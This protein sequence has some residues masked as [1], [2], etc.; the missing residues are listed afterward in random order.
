M[1]QSRRLTRRDLIT[2]MAAGI[3][4]LHVARSD[5]AE[6]APVTQ[7]TQTVHLGVDAGKPRGELKPI[8]RFF[9]CDNPNYTTSANGQLLLGELGKLSPGNVYFRT[10]NLL[11]THDGPQSGRWGSTNA[12]TE[13]ANGNPVYDWS[14]VDAIFDAGIKRG[15]RPYVQLGFM[16]KAMSTRPEPY[17]F[18]WYPGVKYT[19]LFNGWAHPPKDYDKWA[20]L[21][22]QWAKHCLERYGEHE[23]STWYWEPWNE[24]NIDY[25][26]GTQDEWFKLYDYSV[27]AVR[28]ALPHARVGG[29]ETAN[30]P[31]DSYLHDFLEHCARGTNYATGKIGSPLDFI[32]FHAKGSPSYVNGHVRMGIS[33]EIKQ[34]DEAFAVI[35]SF[36]EFAH[37]P[38]V[39]G[40][41][42]PDSCAACKGQQFG[43]RDGP[44]Y[45]SFTAASFA[46][47]HELAEKRDVNL[48]GAITWSF[49]FENE[50][51]FPGLRQL[52]SNGVDLP[53]LNVIRMFSK[54]GGRRLP[55]ASPNHSALSAVMAEGVRGNSDVSALASIDERRLYILAWHYHDD[56]LPGERVTADIVVDNIPW[57]KG[58]VRVT[59]H[60][61]DAEHG[62]AVAEW[63][64]MGSP[65]KPDA[66]QMAKLRDAAKIATFG[67]PKAQLRDSTV[68]LSVALARQSVTLLIIERA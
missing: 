20:E 3:V 58:D 24:P 23:V 48:E 65:P 51:M 9:G 38:I 61:V 1:S 67:L 53:V 14:T 2:A 7:S 13:D 25:W 66:N 30:G 42:D 45:A 39:I 62:N 63:H 26:Q 8:W 54:M 31:G 5:G 49:E 36:P 50:P 37:L 27:A 57:P 43:Y 17:K 29:P 46:R 15:V 56:D 41:A 59:Q 16:P 12:Y 6:P 34:T 40:E 60:L 55:V 35:A 22:Y 11:C 19:E 18:P 10:H 52:S 28:R 44:V 64:A 21:V 4:S 32:S 68:R 33:S 47:I